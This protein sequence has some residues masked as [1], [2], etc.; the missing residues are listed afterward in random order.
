MVAPWSPEITDSGTLGATATDTVV[1]PP[2]LAARSR[3]NPPAGTAW[4][5]CRYR[6]PPCWHSLI[7]PK[8]AKVDEFCDRH[9][10]G[11]FSTPLRSRP[12][13]VRK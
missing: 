8:S 11:F 7:E 13:P 9:S 6:T 2:R 4:P 10:R 5:P 12:L 3:V 1:F